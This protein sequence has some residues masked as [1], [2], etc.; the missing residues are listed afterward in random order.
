MRVPALGQ[1]PSAFTG[2]A[3]LLA[4]RMWHGDRWPT[5]VN[6]GC[7]GETTESFVAGPC[8][9]S[10][11]GFALHD[12]FSG[13][14]LDAAVRFLRAHRG[15]VDLVTVSLWGNDANAFVASCNGNVQCIVDGAPAAIARV[16][17]NLRTLRRAAP[18]ADL[19]V[20]GAYDAKLGAFELTGPIFTALNRTMADAA[21]SARATYVNP[22]PIFDA[23]TAL[24]Y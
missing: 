10:A 8:P 2:Y 14:Q 18:D 22:M 12:T 3:D 13:P 1:P 11:A 7:P 4:A 6:Y 20:I 19:V 17:G 16:A 21:R 9:W 15:R 24:T 5:L 23:M